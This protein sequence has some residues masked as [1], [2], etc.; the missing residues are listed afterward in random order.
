MPFIKW[1]KK[2]NH[3]KVETV[4]ENVADTKTVNENTLLGDIENV[5]KDKQQD[6]S[7]D[8]T[9]DIKNVQQDKEEDVSH[10]QTCDIDIVSE[11]SDDINL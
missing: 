7:H 2:K 6:V 3:L 11:M 1:R 10:D 5:Q 4:A 8:Q 9:C